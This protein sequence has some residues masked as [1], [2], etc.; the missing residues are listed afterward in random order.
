MDE[1]GIE[2]GR[3][4]FFKKE[5]N[6]VLVDILKNSQT[7]KFVLRPQVIVSTKIHNCAFYVMS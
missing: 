5:L 4:I 6:Q 3:E 1:I 7:E 2:L